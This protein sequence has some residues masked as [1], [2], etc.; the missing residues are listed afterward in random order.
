MMLWGAVCRCPVCRQ[1]SRHN[2]PKH[3]GSPPA[4][5]AG[6]L[7]V[8]AKTAAFRIKNYP[9]LGNQLKPHI[10][11]RVGPAL[12]T[13]LPPTLLERGFLTSN[14][15]LSLLPTL[16]AENRFFSSTLQPLS[17]LYLQTQFCPCPSLLWV[18]Q[19]KFIQPFVFP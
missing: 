14:P 6:L 18:K 10:C 19:L 16:D 3:P 2:Y 7:V 1:I 17:F 12:S 13:S 9:S 11:T 4:P 8:A 15:T 5:G